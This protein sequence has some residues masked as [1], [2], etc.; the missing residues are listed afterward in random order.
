MREPA[1]ELRQAGYRYPAAD[2]PALEGLS[3][4]LEPGT[5]T[6]LTGP[7]GCGK[8]TLL[9]LAAG[10]LARHGSGALS[11]AVSVGGADPA[12]LSPAERVARIGFVSQNPVDQ[13]VT[14]TLGDEIAFAA[15][16]AGLDPGTL[17]TTIDR[18]LRAVGLPAEP[19]RAT[20]A[21][22]GGQRQRLVVGAALS[23]GA[24][25]LLLDEPLAHLDPVG[26]QSLLELLRLLADQGHSVLLVEHRLEPCLPLLDRLLVMEGGRLTD[27]WAAAELD[28]GRLLSLGLSVPPLLELQ[29]RFGA[30]AIEARWPE[31]PVPTSLLP[32][33]LLPGPSEPGPGPGPGAEPLLHTPALRHAWAAGGDRTLALDLPPL[34]LFAGERVAVLGGNGAGK[35]T[36]FARLSALRT[37][38]GRVIL[39][40]Q[41]PDLALFSATVGEE[42]QYGPRELLPGDPALPARRAAQAL[43]VED[44]WE[45]APQALSRGQRLRVAV[46]AALASRPALLLLDEPTAGQDRDQVEAMMEALTQSLRGATLLFA[47]HDVDLAA[48]HATRI[49]LLRGGRLVA[50]G[51]PAELLPAI[52]ADPSLLL[53]PF[54]RWCA[55]RGL[56]HRTAAEL[57]R[58]LGSP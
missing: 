20:V 58:T 13:V 46:A 52:E 17:D 14:G 19:D 21:L 6:L 55:A 30:A 34:R 11:G 48:R 16:S 53:P 26:A 23:A 38:C 31:T 49:L 39:I 10:L 12:A 8:S 44:L 43:S 2:R 22:S 47:T 36:L 5:L 9:R 45:M 41:D 42:L 40:P 7:T 24:R 54:L 56:P 33:S 4:S 25:L 1:L 29:H 28:P 35:S 15:E 50:D 32:A 37:P 18:L 3:L 27:D 51:P 57:G